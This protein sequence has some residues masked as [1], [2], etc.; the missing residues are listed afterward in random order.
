MAMLGVHLKK[1]GLIYERIDGYLFQSGIQQ[2]KIILLIDA[3]TGMTDSD[4]EMFKELKKNNKNIIIVITKI[5]KV[6]QSEKQ[7][8]I[9]S[10]KK[11]TG[12]YPVVLFSSVKKLGKDE[13][14]KLIF[15]K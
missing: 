11:I 5:D 12:S 4:Q 8:N 1:R 3:K 6:N 13:L 9:T 14:L 7:K 2:K 10:I 15:S